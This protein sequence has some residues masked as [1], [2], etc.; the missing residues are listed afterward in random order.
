MVYQYDGRASFIT[1]LAWCG[2][3]IPGRFYCNGHETIK[4]DD[5][6]AYMWFKL[7]WL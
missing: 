3:N 5:E 2:M 7:R 4:F 6:A 1:I